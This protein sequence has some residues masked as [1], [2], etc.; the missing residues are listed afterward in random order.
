MQQHRFFR[1][2][3]MLGSALV[4]ITF[5][6][7]QASAQTAAEEENTGGLEEIVVTA[8][9][10][11]QSL[12]DVP[13][14]VT[15]IS[16]ASLETNRI[17]NVSDLSGLAPNVTVRPAAGGTQIASFTVRGVNSYG[18][19][20]G[21]DKQVSLNLDGV[22]ISSARGSIFDMVDIQRIEI[23]RGPQGTLFGRNA[24]AG[25]VSIVT[26]DPTGDFGATLSGTIGNFDQR[27]L[28]A[29]IE[30][31]AFGPLSG[32]ISY[33]HNERRGD[34]VNTNAGVVWDKTGPDGLGKQTSPRT[35]GDHNSE[36]VFATVKLE[37]SDVFKATYK[38][39][40]SGDHFTP[41][42][43]A[44]IVYNP[45]T[46]DGRVIA[47]LIANQVAGTNT[48]NTTNPGIPIGSTVQPGTV[49]VFAPNGRRTGFASAAWT[50]PGYQRNSGH[51]L[52]IEFNPTDDLTVKNIVA[53][54]SNYL[55]GAS[56]LAGLGGLVIT[57]AANA[58]IQANPLIAA[59]TRTLIN[60]SVGNRYLG[61][62]TQRLYKNQQFS[63]ELQINYDSDLLDLT[64]GAIHFSSKEREGGPDTLFSS[65]NRYVAI[66]DN[67]G[68]LPQADG[69]LR[70][71]ANTPHEAIFYN[72]TTSYAAYA[73]AEIHVLPVLDLVAG[74]R[75][76]HDKKSGRSTIGGR[77]N[78][79]TPGDRVNGTMTYTTTPSSLFGGLL[80][81]PAEQQTF[82]YRDNQPSYMFGINFKPNDDLL[83]YGKYSRSYVSG[84]KIANLE[85]KPEIAKSWEA[86][87]KSTLLDGKLRANLSAFHVTY[88]NLQLAQGGSAF[89]LS[90]PTIA[91]VPVIITGVN[92]PF[93][94]K[95]FEAELTA[96]PVVGLTLGASLGYTK[97]KF[98]GTLSALILV[99]AATPMCGAEFGAVA[100][101]ANPTP[102]QLAA[103]A[104]CETANS[105]N[106]R[107]T[108]LPKWTSNLYAQYETEPLFG[109][110]R[111]NFRLDASYRSSMRL[112]ANIDI[113][114]PEFAPA[115]KTPSVWML[116]GRVALTDVK[117][118]A[119][120]TTLALWGRNLTNDK[121]IQ[122]SGGISGVSRAASFTP[123]RTY[124]LDL[125]VKF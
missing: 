98:D 24:T 40:W 118:G 124:G 43:N 112:D 5:A 4:A 123:A 80:I 75:Y 100:G 104:A 41:E 92:V 105:P 83:V 115:E 58:A 61:F 70:I 106:Y 95:G 48:T 125:T 28:R 86:G 81:I 97:S 29:T 103:L 42:G 78:P 60:G 30:L 9:K 54:R 17:V 120:N 19:A 113:P 101:T 6:P 114:T 88:E 94:V 69:T 14:A 3:L 52:T 22:Y 68:L 93:K 62:G 12:Q 107:Q 11:E 37:P 18:V 46:S 50:V 1:T 84:G 119:V 110:A 65:K 79:T 39:D 55:Y 32:Y 34:T 16:E 82:E 36:A 38:F 25:A 66:P 7:K 35:L 56:D 89:A 72:K 33:V 2:S 8:Q 49:P 73:Q 26:R 109:E 99:T 121:S 47:A 10:R 116:N 96:A 57:P 76:T 31:P 64:V 122:F 45:L 90:N 87:I 102:A 74:F 27:R 111:L 20:P 117:L 53:Y 23:L 71:G 77:W 13:I 85:W 21:S 51:N 63:E 15:A 67:T 108:L 91:N 44:A 59:A